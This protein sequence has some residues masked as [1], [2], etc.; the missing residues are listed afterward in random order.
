MKK[1]SL[2]VLLT[3]CLFFLSACQGQADV[4]P[5][6]TA[7]PVVAAAD[8]DAREKAQEYAEEAA[9]LQ[10]EMAE[11]Y[12]ELAEEY[13]EL[14]EEMAGENVELQ[15]E[16][17][18]EAHELQE[19]LAKLYRE[20]A[21]A[22]IEQI[23]IAPGVITTPNIRV[24]APVIPGT[25]HSYG[26]HDR[27]AES[28]LLIPNVSLDNE[29]AGRL[30]EDIQVM[31]L[32]FKDAAGSNTKPVTPAAFSYGRGTGAIMM[33]TSLFGA[34]AQASPKAMW[35]DGYGVVFTMNVDFPLVNTSPDEP[36][37][38]ATDQEKADEVWKRSKNKLKGIEPVEPEGGKQ[39]PV[40]DPDLV[41][42]L[43][44]KLTKA[45]RH[46]SNIR[47]LSDRGKI[48]VVVCGTG[49][50]QQPD[51]DVPTS[52]MTLQAVKKDIDA[53]GAGTMDLDTFKKKV[54]VVV[55]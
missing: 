23:K 15:E 55:Y 50:R 44:E 48:V 12:Q 22:R 25:G 14:Q 21:E 36:A 1:Q 47:D 3:L 27:S 10:E 52:V 51:T 39:K 37:D 45:L 34:P 13:A 31:S 32:I 4:Q 40:F 7:E 43:Q 16:M 46:A 11:E 33:G 35:I 49:Q 42:Q 20:M 19:E 30:T 5:S 6:P 8:E 18:H 54:S 28:V 38:D 26:A 29:V 2:Q 53:F 9:E 17:A 41:Q 24:A